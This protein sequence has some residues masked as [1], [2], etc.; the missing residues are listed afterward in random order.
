MSRR[1]R[2]T[3]IRHRTS[4]R[5]HYV[6][7]RTTDGG[8][9]AFWV[10]G[11]RG[12]GDFLRD[13]RL[14]VLVLI[15]VVLV[16]IIDVRHRVLR[17]SVSE[18]TTGS[19]TLDLARRARRAPRE[20]TLDRVRAYAVY[21]KVLTDVLVQR[22]EWRPR[23]YANRR[24][25]LS[26]EEESRP[27]SREAPMPRATAI[28]AK[29][30][31][32]RRE[33]V[34]PLVFLPFLTSSMSTRVVSDQLRRSRQDG[35]RLRRSSGSSCRGGKSE[36]RCRGGLTTCLFIPFSPPA[37][38]DGEALA[39]PQRS[40]VEE[41]ARLRSHVA[42]GPRSRGAPVRRLEAQ[43]RTLGEIQREAQEI[44]GRQLPFASRIPQV[45]QA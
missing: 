42:G 41:G 18:T 1:T 19:E 31:T 32:D 8:T 3:G 44:E 13:D 40:Q 21:L 22:A 6:T 33:R 45:L 17:G 28:N 10:R 27:S 4:R 12:S 24:T 36:V 25:V 9:A 20:A 26:V 7:F 11:A 43:T 2:S 29:S 15:V 16:G 14:P 34:P 39:R 35:A 23:D 5:R 38:R 37:R 30:T